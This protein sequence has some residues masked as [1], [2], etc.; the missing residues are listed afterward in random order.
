MNSRLFTIWATD[1]LDVQI[2]G[3]GSVQYYGKPHVTQ[4]VTGRGKLSHLG[5]S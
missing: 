3:G 5:E 1:S 2:S 4:Q